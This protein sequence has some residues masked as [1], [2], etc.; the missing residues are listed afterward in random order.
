VWPAWLAHALH[1]RL[2]LMFFAFWCLGSAILLNSELRTGFA[3]GLR[4]F[5]KATDDVFHDD[6]D[7]D[8][9]PMAA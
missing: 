1:S 9:G 8:D 2:W 5:R 7:D 6:N 3:K 4:E